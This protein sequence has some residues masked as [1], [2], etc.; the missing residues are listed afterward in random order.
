MTS[1]SLWQQTSYVQ[2]DHVPTSFIL[3]IHT[4]SANHTIRRSHASWCSSD[5]RSCIHMRLY[6]DRYLS[7]DA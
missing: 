4:P 3:P 6:T 2:R 1:E 7:V 5:W